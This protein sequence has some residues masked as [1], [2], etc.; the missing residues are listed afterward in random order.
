MPQ[1]KAKVPRYEI[2]LPVVGMAHRV[3]QSSRKLIAAR[4]EKGVIPCEILREPDNLH[5]HNAIMVI[6]DGQPFKDMRIGYIARA[7]AA[8]MAPLM[9]EGNLTPIESA[10]TMVNAD[11]GQG[12]L[13]LKFS[14]PVKLKGVKSA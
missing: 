2:E 8:K 5:D 12:L 6:M 1:A 11:E 3:S 9:D 10:L 4:L 13:Y 7:V 14:S